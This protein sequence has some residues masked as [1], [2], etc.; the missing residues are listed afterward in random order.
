LSITTGAW[1]D[2]G[3]F[4]RKKRHAAGKV[5]YIGLS[6]RGEH[7]VPIPGTTKAARVDENAG[8]LAVRFEP[9]DLQ[10]LDAIAERT[11]GDRYAPA[12]M[13]LLNG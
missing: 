5:R 9:D 6:S 3:R 13:G 4:R 1:A 10:K 7:M 11:A 2:N 12:M 8:A